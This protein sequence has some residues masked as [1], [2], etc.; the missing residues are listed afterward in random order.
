M[1][2]EFGE[3]TVERLRPEQLARVKVGTRVRWNNRQTRFGEVLEIA[4][5]TL[6]VREE[7]GPVRTLWVEH[8]PVFA[9]GG[10]T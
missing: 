1:F 10:L 9:L 3:S 7:S 5:E 2:V 8:T 4:G 6:V